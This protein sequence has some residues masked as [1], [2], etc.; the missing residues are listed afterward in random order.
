MFQ[1]WSENLRRFCAAFDGSRGINQPALSRRTAA[2]GRRIPQ[3]VI[4][5]Y[6]HGLEPRTLEDVDVLAM[7]L[8]VT[9]EDLVSAPQFWRV[10]AHQERRAS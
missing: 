10:S 7:A 4:S 6:L 9:R 3:P 1:S 2:L 8:G 5:N